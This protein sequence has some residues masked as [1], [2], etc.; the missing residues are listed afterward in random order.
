M[1]GP[2]SLALNGLAAVALLSAAAG[3]DDSWVRV[4]S[5]HFEVLS[6]AGE[7]PAREA[8]RRLERLRVVLRQIFPAA[9]EVR[10]PI[11]LLVLE[12]E[13]R[14]SGLAPRRS[15]RGPAGLGGFFQGGGERD[16]AVLRL[17]PLQRRP[18]EAAEHE[19]AHLVLNAALP[20]QPVWVAEGLADLLS[21]GLLDE[22]E[23]RLGAAR[24]EYEALLR[25]RSGPT[26]ER[27]LAVGY[28]S[29]EYRGHPET[30]ALYARSWALVRWVVHRRGL[31][32]LCSFLEALAAG[33]EPVAAFAVHLGSLA[34]AGA[35]LLEVPPTP[36]LLVSAGERVVPP[37]EV[38]APA[39]TADVEQRLG[40]LLLHSGRS[41]AAESHLDRALAADPGHVFDQQPD[42]TEVAQVLS[43]L[44]LKRGDLDAA[45]RVLARARDAARD[46]TGRY[47]A[48]HQLARLEGFDGGAEGDIHQPGVGFD[49]S[50]S[51]R[52]G[53][54]RTFQKKRAVKRITTDQVASSMIQ[55]PVVISPPPPAPARPSTR[56]RRR[57]GTR[58]SAAPAWR[59]P[60]A[61]G[62]R[63]PRRRSTGRSPLRA[64]PSR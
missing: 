32:G 53:R 37:L 48:S 33:H 15:D 51:A 44:Y 27:L 46:P 43:K 59:P 29:P 18:F 49:G 63:S 17:S 58:P 52:V 36:L 11:T 55:A 39:A 34:E 42:R 25:E 62:S 26:L 45:R 2:V 50:S 22:D 1:L 61:P 9:S 57:A 41:M 38:E 40:D 14:F 35:T 20:A 56:G 3:G 60:R 4:R 10:R 16:Y 13:A 12:G 47:L 31:P 28:D 5:P 23:A 64:A 6:D 54:V 24:P 30:E 21:G 7:A 19:Y 8:A